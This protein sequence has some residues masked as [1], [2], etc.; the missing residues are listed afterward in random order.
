MPRIAR[1]VFAGIPHHVTQR[2]NRRENVFFIDEYRFGLR[3]DG[4]VSTASVH[5]KVFAGIE[6][7]SAW[8]HEEDDVTRLGILLRNSHKNLPCGSDDFVDHLERLAGRLLRS[9]PISRSKKG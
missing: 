9:R 1:E 8:L 4:L 2:G 5:L 6:N 7:W 3:R